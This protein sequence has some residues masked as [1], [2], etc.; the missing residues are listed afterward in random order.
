[1]SSN[2]TPKNLQASK[3]SKKTESKNSKQ[4]RRSKSPGNALRKPADKGVTHGKRD[5]RDKPYKGGYDGKGIDFAK[6]KSALTN[7]YPMDPDKTIA[8]LKKLHD[9]KMP[10]WDPRRR[11]VD[12]LTKSGD[13][14]QTYSEWK[15]QCDSRIL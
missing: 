15:L 7:V 5:M 12:P 10:L 1:M 9:A 14:F 6:A 3:L 11:V 13:R 2:F 4:R 8:H